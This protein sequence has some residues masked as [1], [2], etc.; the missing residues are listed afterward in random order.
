MQLGIRSDVFT[1][2]PAGSGLVNDA[3]ALNRLTGIPDLIWAGL[4]LIISLVMLVFF[5]SRAASVRGRDDA[6][7]RP[8]EHR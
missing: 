3:V 2:A 8:N 4:W 7:I 5:L 6:L 1:F